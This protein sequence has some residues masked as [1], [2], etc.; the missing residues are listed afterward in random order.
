[1][2]VPAF[3]AGVGRANNANNVN[4]ANNAYGVASG[5]VST[6]NMLTQGSADFAKTYH[7]TAKHL[8]V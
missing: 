1:M 7:G 8:V 5:N 3:L 2:A 4:N 6:Y